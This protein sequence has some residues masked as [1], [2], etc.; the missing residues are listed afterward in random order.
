MLQG[1]RRTNSRVNV[2]T[3]DH[4]RGRLIC[5]AGID[6]TGKTTL[7]KKLQSELEAAG[8][9]C[10]Y[11]WLRNARVLSVPFLALC[12]LTGFAQSVTVRGKRAGVYY[13]YKNKLVAHLWAWISAVDML[14]VSLWKI[15]LPLR[16][17]NTVI[18]DRYVLDAL[19]DLMTD[20]RMTDLSSYPYK[21]LLRRL[22][23]RSLTVV[24]TVDEGESL[25]RKDD[26]IS[27]AYLIQ[28]RKLYLSVARELRIPVIDAKPSIEVVWSNLINVLCRQIAQLARDQS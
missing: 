16:R 11:V 28:R 6:G 12:Y 25:R 18:A 3:M 20:T 13:F 17:G 27:S 8:I 9:S 5:L 22:G 19:V 24:L 2:D 14:V 15:Q 10:S 21:L 4:F 26:S 1:R 7:A 23:R